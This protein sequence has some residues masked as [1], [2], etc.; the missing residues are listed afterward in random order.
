M[1]DDVINF[2]SVYIRFGSLAVDGLGVG[3]FSFAKGA[4][5]P[6]QCFYPTLLNLH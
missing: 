3:I 5:F 2:N 4:D 6:K 1:D